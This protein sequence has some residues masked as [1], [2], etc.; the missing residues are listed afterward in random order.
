MKIG[1]GLLVGVLTWVE[2][3]LD[4]VTLSLLLVVVLTANAV[5]GAYV[6]FRAPVPGVV[7]P[8]TTDAAP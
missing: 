4:A 5:Y 2:I 6:W 1:S 8:A 7:P 3:G